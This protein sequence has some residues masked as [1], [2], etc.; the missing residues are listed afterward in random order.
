MKKKLWAKWGKKGTEKEKKR[1]QDSRPE[2]GEKPKEGT[3]QHLEKNPPY[4][5]D[6]IPPRE[7][8][9][10]GRN[11]V[12]GRQK[13][14]GKVITQLIIGG[15]STRARENSQILENARWSGKKKIQEWQNE[16][17]RDSPRDNSGRGARGSKGTAEPNG[18]KK[19]CRDRTAGVPSIRIQEKEEGTAADS[20]KKQTKKGS[21]ET[22]GA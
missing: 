7:P 1:Q 10:Q 17:K 5:P 4:L 19:A 2:A 13:V 21:Q 6:E 22:A 11:N 9:K 12:R 14:G 15:E 20:S 3:P 8:S 16:K 18:E